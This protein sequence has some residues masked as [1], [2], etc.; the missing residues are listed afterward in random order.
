MDFN[1]LSLKHS[2]LRYPLKWRIL[3]RS[4]G[5]CPSSRHIHHGYPGVCS[6]SAEGVVMKQAYLPNVMKS[7]GHGFQVL[8]LIPQGAPPP[9]PPWNW[10]DKEHPSWT[11]IYL[12]DVA[13]S[14]EWW[15]RHKVDMPIH[16]I[17]RFVFYLHILL[18]KRETKETLLKCPCFVCFFWVFCWVPVRQS[19]WVDRCWD[20][21]CFTKDYLFKLLLIGDS[22]R[23]FLSRKSLPPTKMCFFVDVCL[24]YVFYVYMIS[25]YLYIS[26]YIFMYIYIY[27]YMYLCIYIYIL[28]LLQIL[29]WDIAQRMRKTF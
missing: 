17:Y 5:T 3:R 18:I 19:F 28:G 16:Y 29:L 24:M 20:F 6:L 21:R 2:S 11:Y 12:E 7:G 25:I 14:D 8:H 15:D 4:T 27:V 13:V 10:H 23:E 22:G 26:G 9:H 1:F